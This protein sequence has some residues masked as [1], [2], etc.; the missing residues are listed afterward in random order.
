MTQANHPSSPPDAGRRWRTRGVPFVLGA[1]VVVAWLGSGFYTVGT[2]ERGVVTRFG[3][4]CSAIPT[5]PGLHYAL[6]WPIDRVYTPQTTVVRWIEV[7]FTTLGQKSSERRR[8]DMLTGDENILKIM[9]VVQYKI[10]DSAAYLFASEDP[11]FLVE[12]TVES[13]MNRLVAEREVDAVL[14]TAKDDIQVQAIKIAQE[15]LNAYGAGIWLLGGNL[16]RDD[17]P[18]P[19]EE[20]F[21][22][23][24]S[25]KKDRERTMDEAREYAG[26]MIPEAH[27]QAQQMI[28]RAHGFYAER[29][30]RAQGDASRFLSL[31]EE[32]RLAKEITRTRLYVDSMERVFSKMKVV[33][34]NRAEGEGE[35]RIHIVE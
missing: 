23:V 24:T 11:H 4:V 34:V 28:S 3:R 35:S 25:A 22:D 29:L 26:R 31:L 27:G 30:N 18:V 6:P 17:P 12:R 16:Q 2:N 7:G 14:T 15:L 8:S 20:A 19:V 21:K 5:A 1:V 13:A 32:Y 10:R 33:V 9:M